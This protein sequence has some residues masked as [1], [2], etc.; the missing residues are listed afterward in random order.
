MLKI[1]I[2]IVTYNNE[3]EI[4]ICIESILLSNSDLEILIVDNYSNDKT[5]Q[6]LKTFGNKIKIIE[7]GK[8]L[9]FGKASN[10]GAKEANGEYLIFLN[11]DTKNI[12]N[13]FFEK[14]VTY[15]EKNF[16][17][18][19]ISPAIINSEK[20]IVKS[21]RKLPTAFGAFRE[22]ILGQKGAY[23]FYQP[24]YDGL[25]AVECI[26]GACIAIKKDF[27]N[28]LGGFNEKYFMYFEDI[29]L[30]REINKAGFK[31]GYL[32]NLQIEHVVGASGFGQPTSSFA[33]TSS[34]K[35]H[36]FFEYYLI[37]LILIIVRVK[38]K[39]KKNNLK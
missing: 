16:S 30:C 19:L 15:L 13:N 34:R 17:Y 14:L 29:E 5:L 12:A 28:K 38:N 26:V 21:V 2:I 25:C 7:S 39:I 18:G 3:K 9:G 24:S 8:N 11:P 20:K 32:P 10:L 1:S 37:E 33:K 4:K 27:F 31:I 6:I 23:D 22:Y 36:G 35:Y